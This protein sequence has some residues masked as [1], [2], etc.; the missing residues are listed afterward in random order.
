[1]LG[2]A[3]WSPNGWPW[4][5]DEYQT[6]RMLGYPELLATADIF[7]HVRSEKGQ[8]R[9]QFWL[10][11]GSRPLP[12]ALERGEAAEVPL[13]IADDLTHWHSLGRVNSVRLRVRFTNLQ[14]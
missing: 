14:P 9:T 2:D 7:Y 3:H 13:R 10:P 12:V 11:G 8:G 1:G 4:S 6:L 5:E